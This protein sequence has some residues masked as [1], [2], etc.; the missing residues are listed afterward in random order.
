MLTRV[1]TRRVLLREREPG[2]R[3]QVPVS[4]Q[5]PR[6]FPE[7]RAGARATGRCVRLS[8]P[9]SPLAE[10]LS[11]GRGLRRGV[12]CS[13]HLVTPQYFSSLLGRYPSSLVFDGLTRSQGQA[14]FLV[15]CPLLTATGAEVA[16]PLGASSCLRPL[17][18]WI[19]LLIVPEP[20]TASCLSHLCGIPGATKVGDR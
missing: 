1:S 15:S 2:L 8:R 20:L 18:T 7:P 14:S 16:P 11:L 6:R 13:V 19:I 9:F 5:R 10:V 12:V 3:C 4:F 17:S